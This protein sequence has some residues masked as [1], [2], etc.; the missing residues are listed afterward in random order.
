MRIQG[1]AKTAIGKEF[2]LVK[3]G[4]PATSEYIFYCQTG[5]CSC[6]GQCP[7]ELAAIKNLS[8]ASNSQI[9]KN[10]VSRLLQSVPSPQ[11][12]QALELNV[13]QESQAS[14]SVP[15][16]P[17]VT[18]PTA[19]PSGYGPKSPS[20]SEDSIKDY[21]LSLVA[22]GGKRYSYIQADLALSGK[23]ID[24]EAPGKSLA[25]NDVEEKIKCNEALVSTDALSNAKKQECRGS[26]SEECSKGLD[27]A[28]KQSGL[29]ERLMKKPLAANALPNICDNTTTN[30]SENAC[31]DWLE[32][33][34]VLN[35][36]SFSLRGFMDLQRQID[37]FQRGKKTL[38]Y[39]ETLTVSVDPVTKNDVKAVL[40]AS[41]TMMDASAISV[42]DATA[43]SAPSVDTKVSSFDLTSQ[44]VTL[45]KNYLRFAVYT[46]M[47]FLSLLL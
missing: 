31:F 10:M 35:S 7:T 8:L 40:P 15:K 23:V 44:T 25:K 37:I 14:A 11:V 20:S 19:R 33:I 1:N 30:Y 21:L 34:I 28:C 26:M 16:P 39:L 47:I 5:A 32:R 24:F 22:M 46:L 9:I 29:Y 42:D 36:L 45:G 3:N 6:T 17:Q 4:V 12:S 41:I 18:Q 13:L 38:R 27:G 2:N 43:V